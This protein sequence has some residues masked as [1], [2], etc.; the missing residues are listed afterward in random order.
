M[1]AKGQLNNKHKRPG[2]PGIFDVQVYLQGSAELNMKMIWKFR[3]GFDYAKT[4][5]AVYK[6]VF[7]KECFFFP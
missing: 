1:L 5:E 4:K 6:V 7:N 3:F 2:I